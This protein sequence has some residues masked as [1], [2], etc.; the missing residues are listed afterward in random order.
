MWGFADVDE[1]RVEG[2]ETGARVYG[3]LPPASHLVVTPVGIDADGFVDG[4]PH[5]A[6]LPSAYHR[7]LLT[8]TDPF[9]RP[10]TEGLQML[11]R[12][13]F[14]TSFLID[15]QLADDGLV[16]RGAIVISSASSKTSIGAAY[17]LA[18]RSGAEIVGLTSPRSAE[19]VEGLGIYTRCVTYDRI[20]ELEQRPATFV[21][22]AGD[23]EIRQAV[24]TQLADVLERSIAVGVTHWE[25]GIPGGE[26]LPGPAPT[27]F[28][29]PDRATKR[30]ADWGRAGLNDRVAEAWHGFCDWTAGWLQI[31]EDEGFDAVE[32]V[33]H[34]VLEA[35]VTPDRANVLRI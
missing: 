19:F 33:Y 26:P 9:Y 34:D 25:A 15:D 24:H 7:Y 32:R 28:F 27:F 12:P 3:Y 6:E 30:S 31:D 14:F 21:D 29:A 2:V 1:S 10:D 20:A 18:Q 35:R 22:V 4:A 23:S 8:D 16:E 13:L 5:R 11:L 17:L